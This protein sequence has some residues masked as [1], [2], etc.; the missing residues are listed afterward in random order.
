MQ[1]GQRKIP[2]SGGVDGKPANYHWTQL[3]PAVRSG[4]GGLPAEGGGAE[5]RSGTDVDE[6][7]IR[8]LP[9]ASFTLLTD[10]A[11]A[12]EVQVGASASHRPNVLI[13]SLA[14]E[15]AGQRGIRFSDA[16]PEGRAAQADRVRR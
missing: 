15:L 13:Q 8:P 5:A 16:E 9:K 12:Y 11:E 1:T 2:V 10:S 4:A 7:S 6:S 3:L 14:P